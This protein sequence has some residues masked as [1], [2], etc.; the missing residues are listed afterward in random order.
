[1][2]TFRPFNFSDQD[3]ATIVA[4]HDAFRPDDPADEANLR[5]SDKIR[6]KTR[7]H[8]RI[9][10]E[11]AGKPVG[12]GAVLEMSYSAES[13]YYHISWLTSADYRNQGICSAF[14]EYALAKMHS[15]GHIVAK[16]HSGTRE[17]QP[18]SMRW[19]TTHDFVQVERY[20]ISILAL[21]DFDSTQFTNYADRPAQHGLTI[22]TL[23]EI[24]PN[25]PDWQRKVYDLEWVFEQ[26]EPAADEPK[27]EPF[28][29]YVKG[30]FENP[31]FSPQMWFVALDGDRFVGMSQLW[32]NK[33]KPHEL[34]VGWTGVDR[35][36]RKKG[37]AMAMKLATINFALQHPTVTQ[38]ETD[39]HETNW[40]YQINLR[41]GFKPRPAS[42]SY[43]KS[44]D[45]SK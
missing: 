30:T 28:A 21:A 45:T 35:P 32:P 20:P 38:I 36:Y 44:F 1:M 3:Y 17:D 43:N 39:N 8:N 4:L 37:L 16:L 24:I 12:H 23:A 34:V 31:D 42:I 22:K 15:D 40:M 26:D 41:L 6:P 13:N 9:I 5:R 27:Q 29:E 33:M 18:Q 14:Y 10:A 7:Y 2:L 11:I 25:D 19:L